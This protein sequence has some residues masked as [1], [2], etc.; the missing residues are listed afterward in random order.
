MVAIQNNSGV[1]WVHQDPI[2]KSQRVTDDSGNVTAV[3]DLDP[4]GGETSRSS[5]SAF[6][7]H[8][9]TSYT[10]DS[11]GGDDAMMRRYQSNWNRFSQPDPYDGSY[12]AADPQSFNRYAYVQNDPVSFV[13]PNG[14]LP[15]S[16]WNSLFEDGYFISASQNGWNQM[17]G[18]NP[19]S[20]TFSFTWHIGDGYWISERTTITLWNYPYAFRGARGF[21]RDAEPTAKESDDPCDP[22]TV[23][24]TQRD[25]TQIANLV[26]G[27]LNADWSIRVGRTS[28]VGNA[29]SN[30]ER[31]GFSQFRSY[32]PDHPGVNLQGQLNG[33]WFHVTVTPVSTPNAAVNANR[34]ASGQNSATNSGR[35]GS[36]RVREVTAHC[37]THKPDSWAHAWDYFKSFFW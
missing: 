29:V 12:D 2:T 3:V 9:Y 24:Q 20:F 14:L 26:G 7:P 8:R 28:T 18:L 32:N 30:L 21:G 19:L 25:L 6:Q 34:S 10:R 1:S 13:D 5:N 11:N 33:R 31:A 35:Q 4:W 27:T 37:E 22:K 36:S 17:Y 23:A 15:W 16:L